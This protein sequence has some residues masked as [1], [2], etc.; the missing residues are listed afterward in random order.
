MTSP[1]RYIEDAC[2]IYNGSKTLAQLNPVLKQHGYRIEVLDQQQLYENYFWLI[3]ND[4]HSS[5]KTRQEFIT[6][7][8]HKDHQMFGRS[9]PMVILRKI[10]PYLYKGTLQLANPV[11]TS[12]VKYFIFQLR[13]LKIQTVD[14]NITFC[15]YSDGTIALG[16]SQRYHLS[17]FMPSEVE[18]GQ[19]DPFNASLFSINKPNV[20][21]FEC[22]FH[23][24]EEWEKGMEY[25][26]EMFTLSY[27]TEDLRIKLLLLISCLESLLNRG[28][29]QIRHIISRHVA[30][31]T[32]KNKT[33][34]TLH[35]RQLKAFYDKRSSITHGQKLYNEEEIYVEDYR[36]LHRFVRQVITYCLN[37]KRD[38]SKYITSKRTL[39]DV[40]FE[41]LNSVGFDNPVSLRK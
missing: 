19:K 32:A 16:T 27:D 30:L 3:S 34:F 28:R 9:Y 23:Y 29:D 18:E 12:F 17:R 20:E 8:M 22:S 36:D 6:D 31:I 41:H 10:D 5:G 15:K 13:L 21:Q 38:N 2:F 35:Y 7:L 26:I 39:P 33:E 40:L 1:K 4:Y 14:D 11:F 25:A 24:D 37:F